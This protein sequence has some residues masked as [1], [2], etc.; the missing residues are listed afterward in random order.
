MQFFL[1]S[2]LENRG[3]AHITGVTI[4]FFK[5]GAVAQR[6]RDEVPSEVQQSALNRSW[7]PM[8]VQSRIF[9]FANFRIRIACVFASFWMLNV[10]EVDVPGCS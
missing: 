4:F 6:L 8:N 10:D 3:W 9:S 1:L 5:H 2:V 7:D